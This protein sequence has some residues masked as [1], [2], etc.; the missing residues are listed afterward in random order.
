MI[1]FASPVGAAFNSH[2]KESVM[3]KLGK[4]SIETKTAKKSL[5]ETGGFSPA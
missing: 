5:S 3:I 1:V 2:C 4:V